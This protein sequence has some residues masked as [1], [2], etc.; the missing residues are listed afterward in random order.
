MGWH[1]AMGLAHLPAVK[2][3]DK[4]ADVAREIEEVKIIEDVG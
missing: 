1:Q 3:A 4:Y 2:Y